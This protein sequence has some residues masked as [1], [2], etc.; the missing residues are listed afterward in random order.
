VKT[1]VTHR[2]ALVLIIFLAALTTWLQ[3]AVQDDA[4]G[5]AGAGRHDPDAIVENFTVLRLGETG[6]TQYT[7]S[8]PRMQH[9]SG[10]DS[11]EVLYPRIVYLADDGGNITA[12]ASR[13]T[14]ARGNEDET[15][16]YGNALIVREATPDRGELR[17]RTEFLRLLP[18]QG[19]V[20]TDRTVIITEGNSVLTGVGMEVNKDKQQFSLQSQVRGIFDAP[21]KK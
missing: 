12:S 17:A 1:R 2:L 10:N 13:G 21:G 5:D 11:S 16:L 7:F 20:R 9:F 15:L 8:A 4:G 14:L 3:Y 6:K 19:I 18:E